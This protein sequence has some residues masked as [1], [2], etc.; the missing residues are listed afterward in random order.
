MANCRVCGKEVTNE[1][2]CPNC[3]SAINNENKVDENSSKNQNTKYCDK[4]GEPIDESMNFCSNCGN[5][6]SDT[7]KNIYKY[8]YPTPIQSISIPLIHQNK[9]IISFCSELIFSLN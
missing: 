6:F 1:K 5:N 9:N 4:C 8:E 2:F 7:M 3:G